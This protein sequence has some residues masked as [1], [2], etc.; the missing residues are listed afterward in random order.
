MI[1]EREM[2]KCAYREFNDREIDAVL[3]RMHPDVEWANGLEGGHVYG[4]EE[5]RSYWLRQ[6]GMVDP[7]VEPVRI[8]AAETGEFTV[9]VHQIVHDLVGNLLADTVVYHTYR[10]RYGLIER[11]DIAHENPLKDANA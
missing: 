10:I 2:L 9:E 6:F 7:H 11:M 5:V 1:D 8:E 3:A 4:R